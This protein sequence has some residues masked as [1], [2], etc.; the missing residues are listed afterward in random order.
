MVH[1]EEDMEDPLE[2]SSIFID[3]CGSE[4]GEVGLI[5]LYIDFYCTGGGY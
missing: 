3:L 1:K 4:R 2:S 5:F